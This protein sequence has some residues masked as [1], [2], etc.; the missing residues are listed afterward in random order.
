MKN[1]IVFG[2]VVV[3]AVGVGYYFFFAPGQPK[4]LENE[5]S[6]FP[7][8]TPIESDS[9][10]GARDAQTV[11]VE[12]SDFQCP[13]CAAYQ[14]IVKQIAEEFDGKLAIV[15]RHL[16]LLQHKHAKIAAY[17]AEAAGKQGKFWEMHDMIFETQRD[18]SSEK[19][20]RDIFIGY[21]EALGLDRAQFITDIDSNEIADKV[22]AHYKSGMQAGV[23]GTPTFFLNGEKL[24]TPRTYED[25]KNAVGE[26][27]F[28]TQ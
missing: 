10:K 20:A 1:L 26:A 11:L 18:W 23:T 28:N 13:A 15:Y 27:I 17:S 2:V 22:S 12:Y 8:D 9:V 24:D 6:S 3:V 19:D 14:P 5:P 25:F 7:I 16:P 4:S 21:A